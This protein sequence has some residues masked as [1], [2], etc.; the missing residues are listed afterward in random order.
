[1]PDSARV[2]VT[3]SYMFA[4]DR[5]TPGDDPIR[6]DQEIPNGIARV[7]TGDASDPTVA[8]AITW[9]QGRPECVSGGAAAR[10][11]AVGDLLGG[12]RLQAAPPAADD[13]RRPKGPGVVF[14]TA[15][16]LPR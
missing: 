11:P 14:R 12:P 4:R 16:P 10:L 2:D 5:F 7:I 6:P 8:A 15:M 13:P 9:L 1:M 3:D